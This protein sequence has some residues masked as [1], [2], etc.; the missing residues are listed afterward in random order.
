LILGIL[1][2]RIN[3]GCEGQS[4]VEDDWKSQNILF[5]GNI[6]Q[7]FAKIVHSFCQFEELLLEN[8]ERLWNSENIVSE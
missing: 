8:L 1:N 4:A 2:I 3:D 5:P 7:W 6:A